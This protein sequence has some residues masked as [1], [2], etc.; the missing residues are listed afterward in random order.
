[1]AEGAEIALRP[2]AATGDHVI[3]GNEIQLSGGGQRV[4]FELNLS[5]WAPVALK[6][7]QATLDVSDLGQ[8]CA[9]GNNDGN[10]C[11]VDVHCF[12]GGVCA[13]TRPG[14]VTAAVQVCTEDADCVTAFGDPGAKCNTFLGECNA[15][16]QDLGRSDEWHCRS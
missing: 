3:V 12:G 15:G 13:A 9:G 8:A 5:G 11:Y 2:I 16:W 6:T 14:P 10:T 7:W 1:M 4:F